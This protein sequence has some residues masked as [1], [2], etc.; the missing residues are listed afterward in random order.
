MRKMLLL[1]IKIAEVNINGPYTL[2]YGHSAVSVIAQYNLLFEFHSKLPRK[3]KKPLKQVIILFPNFSLRLA[4]DF[5]RIFRI[6]KGK[7]FTKLVFVEDIASM[8]RLV[9]PTQLTLPPV[10]MHWEDLSKGLNNLKGSL[11]SLVSIFDPALGAPAL[12]HNCTSYLRKQGLNKEGLFRAAG[13]QV[14]CNLAQTRWQNGVGRADRNEPTIIIGRDGDSSP[15]NSVNLSAEH[16]LGVGVSLA[17]AVAD[18]SQVVITDVD[19][20]AQIMKM[21]LRD[22]AEPLITFDAFE[23]ILMATAAVEAG[24]S[25]ESQWAETVNEALF[26]MP[27]EHQAT[28]SFLIE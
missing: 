24:G 28:L 25:S 10:F 2:V 12:L 20:V 27:Y 3:Y 19:T 15:T 16:E 5:S 6:V 9:P 22:L 17:P 18:L 11:P 7:F 21:T 4:L 14:T 23:K 13:D 8:Q 1:F 26:S